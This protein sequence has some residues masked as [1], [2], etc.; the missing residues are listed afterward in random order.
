[1]LVFSQQK[2]TW[3]VPCRL[4]P[5]GQCWMLQCY[6]YSGLHT[7]SLMATSS[8]LLD[9]TSSCPQPCRA[10]QCSFCQHCIS[11]SWTD[12]WA[13]ALKASEPLV[14]ETQLQQYVYR[15]TY[16]RNNCLQYDPTKTVRPYKLASMVQSLSAQNATCLHS[17]GA[18][19]SRNSSR[20][21]IGFRVQLLPLA[22]SCNSSRI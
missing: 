1:M 5:S 6:T 8:S 2:S 9:P 12:A 13:C 19:S 4:C 20:W 21:L 11:V 22:S 17:E 15:Y 16:A 18:T 7:S 14:H 10:C 3:L